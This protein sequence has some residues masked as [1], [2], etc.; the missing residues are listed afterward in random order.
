MVI[1]DGNWCTALGVMHDD[2][3]VVNGQV[4]AVIC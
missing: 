4:V 3:V 1:G 2:N